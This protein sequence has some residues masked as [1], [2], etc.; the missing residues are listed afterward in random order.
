MWK[1]FTL[2]SDKPDGVV[3]RLGISFYLLLL[4]VHIIYVS[5]L[6]GIVFVNSEY[7]NVF[8]NVVHSIL[9]IF[10]MY[11]FNP[12]NKTTVIKEYDRFIIFNVALFLLFNLGILEVLKKVYNVL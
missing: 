5:T 2:I 7:T 6:V 10:L 11:R 3:D 4:L 1:Y 9:C 12:Y 8:T